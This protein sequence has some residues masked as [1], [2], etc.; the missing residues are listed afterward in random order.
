MLD[1]EDDI[2]K[3]VFSRKLII[4]TY[5]GVQRKHMLEALL[6]LWITSRYS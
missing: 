3:A 2:I 6:M 1:D 5:L 4:P